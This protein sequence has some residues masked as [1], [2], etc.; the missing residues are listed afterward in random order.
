MLNQIGVVILLLV[1]AQA[2]LRHHALPTT[3]GANSRIIGGEVIAKGAAPYQV[4]MQNIYGNHM[5]GGVII[6]DQYVLTAASCVAGLRKAN[7]KVVMSTNEWAGEA[8]QYMVDDIIPHCNFDKPLY[9]NDIALIKLSTLVAYD[10]VTQNITIA[11]LDD[12]QDGEKLKLTGWGNEDVNGNAA[13]ELKSIDLTYVAPEKCR[14]T[15]QNSE[16]LDIG[17]LCAVGSVGA[18][19]CYGDTGGPLVDSQGRLVGIAN[20]GVPCGYGFPDVFARISYYHDWIISTING[21][22]IY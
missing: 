1:G 2:A 20:W 22:S 9:H 14:N 18:G 12:L 10:D 5:C 4:S 13:W 8:Y 21:C 3:S 19:A 16:D 17:H 11:S 15:Y 6:H 7:I